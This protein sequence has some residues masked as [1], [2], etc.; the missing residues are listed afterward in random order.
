[1]YVNIQNRIQGENLLLPGRMDT[2]E[3]RTQLTD[4]L[5]EH[6]PCTK[7]ELNRSWGIENR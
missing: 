2:A 6:S 1:M 3:H 5:L 4:H 7:R